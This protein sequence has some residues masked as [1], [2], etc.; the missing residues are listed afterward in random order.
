MEKNAVTAENQW[1]ISNDWLPSKPPPAAKLQLY[2][3][4]W[5]FHFAI[6][7]YCATMMRK[8]PPFLETK[9]A[10]GY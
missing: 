7:V 2:R 3:D 4:G 10:V 6:D 8:R 9:A 5:F 1:N